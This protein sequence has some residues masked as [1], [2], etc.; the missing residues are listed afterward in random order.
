MDGAGGRLQMLLGSGREGAGLSSTSASE[1]HQLTACAANPR[2]AV[3]DPTQGIPGNTPWVLTYWADLTPGTSCPYTP[4]NLVLTACTGSQLAPFLVL[5]AAHCVD[6]TGLASVAGCA[7]IQVV[8]IVACYG[9]TRTPPGNFQCPTDLSVESVG[10]SWY[11]HPTTTSPND[12]S[13]IFLAS[14][15]PG[16]YYEVGGCCAVRAHVCVCVCVCARVC[17]CVVLV[18]CKACRSTHGCLRSPAHAC[19]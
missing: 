12:Q 13:I 5:A 18:A 1:P 10:V 16:P 3:P 4:T 8:R 15:R 2:E 17:V 11:A 6:P 14:A 7:N 9:Y 19:S